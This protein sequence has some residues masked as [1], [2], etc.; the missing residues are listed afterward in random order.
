MGGA[1]LVVLLLM[2][3]S[4]E[5]LLIYGIAIQVLVATLIWLENSTIWHCTIYSRHLREGTYYF[6]S[7][8]ISIVL[9]YWIKS[10]F[11]NITTYF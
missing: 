8:P 7:H 2:L 1:P 6:W 9:R 5:A 10:N 3:L 11:N 4:M